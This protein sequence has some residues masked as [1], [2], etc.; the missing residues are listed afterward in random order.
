MILEPSGGRME[1]LDAFFHFVG[2][3]KEGGWEGSQ[4]RALV[5]DEDIALWYGAHSKPSGST[6]PLSL[7]SEPILEFS[8]E[9]PSGSTLLLSNGQKNAHFFSFIKKA[10][11]SL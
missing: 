10:F 2:E 6:R 11:L 7:H 5:T 9:R 8:E 4:Y 1:R 3:R